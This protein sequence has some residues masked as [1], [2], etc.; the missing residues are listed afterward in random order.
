MNVKP[1]SEL[2]RARRAAG[3]S[4]GE[5]AAALGVSSAYCSRIEHGH[6]RPSARFKTAAVEVLGRNLSEALFPDSER[7]RA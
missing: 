4:L 3:L 7:T 5:F 1:V 2:E 6:E